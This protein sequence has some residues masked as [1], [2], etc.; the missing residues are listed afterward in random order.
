MRKYRTRTFYTDSQK[1]LMRDGWKNHHHKARFAVYRHSNRQHATSLHS[2]FNLVS[3]NTF[4][5]H[6]IVVR[7]EVLRHQCGGTSFVV[8]IQTVN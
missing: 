6:R 1:A 8:L 3:Q 4:H 2:W 7:A 5:S